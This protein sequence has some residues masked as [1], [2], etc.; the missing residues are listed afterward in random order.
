MSSVGDSG[1]AKCAIDD[2][3]VDS[4]EEMD[5]INVSHF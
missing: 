1:G 3:L 2:Q 5:E 4:W